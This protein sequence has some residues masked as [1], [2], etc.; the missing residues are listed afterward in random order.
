MSGCST[1]PGTI[2]RTMTEGGRIANLLTNT[3][4]CMAAEALAKARAL[5]S[6]KACGALCGVSQAGPQVPVPSMLLNATVKNC[7]NTYQSLEGCVPESIRIAR[8]QQRTLDMSIDATNPGARFSE[9]ARNFPA[10]CP[11]IP[12]LYIN[13]GQ[14][15]LQGS[16][17]GL[18]NKPGNPVLPI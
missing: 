16:S 7:F 5:G 1:S 17:C 2:D 15:I 18:P 6:G 9:Y 8:L 11:P 12:A 3:R 14:P 4:A 10:P 13:A